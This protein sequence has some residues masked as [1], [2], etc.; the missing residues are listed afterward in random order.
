VAKIEKYKRTTKYI[1]HFK[2]AAKKIWPIKLI[3]GKKGL[4]PQAPRY[5]SFKKLMQAK[6]MSDIF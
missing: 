2:E 1:V 3:K 4:A 6:T 5:T